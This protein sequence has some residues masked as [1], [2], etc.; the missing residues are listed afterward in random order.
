MSRK[1]AASKMEMF[2]W[3]IYI[4]APIF[5]MWVSNIPETAEFFDKYWNRTV[6]SPLRR[7]EGHR[8]MPTDMEEVKSRVEELKAKAGE[9]KTGQ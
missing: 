7:A 8:V 5:A 4:G 2:R 1:A 6:A 3:V 9:P